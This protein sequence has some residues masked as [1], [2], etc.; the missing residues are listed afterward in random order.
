[1]IEFGIRNADRGFKNIERFQK[2]ER[3]AF[4]KLETKAKGKRRKAEVVD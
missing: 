3:W 4:E 2:L 1:M